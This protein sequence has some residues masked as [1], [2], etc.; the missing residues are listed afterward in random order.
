MADAGFAEIDVDEARRRHDGGAPVVDVREPDEYAAGHVPGAVNIPLGQLPERLAE[1]P[2]SEHLLVVCQL[3]GRSAR[4][5]GILE[6]QGVAAT[7]V[8]GGTAAW[9]DAGFPTE[10]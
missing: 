5:C 7:N 1:V 3:G 2:D 10:R 6:S 4:A 9:I 8:A